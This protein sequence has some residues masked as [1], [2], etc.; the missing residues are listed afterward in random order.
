VTQAL[1]ALGESQRLEE[2]NG[3]W[4]NFGAKQ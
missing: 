3:A 2:F 4:L 1:A